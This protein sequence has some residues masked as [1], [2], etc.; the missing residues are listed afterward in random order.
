MPKKSVGKKV[1]LRIESLARDDPVPTTVAGARPVDRAGDAVD[2]YPGP[3]D[4]KAICSGHGQTFSRQKGE[5]QRAMAGCITPAR[6][7]TEE[8]ERDKPT[9]PGM[10]FIGST[11]SRGKGRSGSRNQQRGSIGPGPFPL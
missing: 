2:K 10:R 5:G 1:P 3:H 8:E 6:R 11:S 9:G 7:P 4:G